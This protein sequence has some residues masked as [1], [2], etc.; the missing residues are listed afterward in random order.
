M[1]EKSTYET[2]R[3]TENELM[4]LISEEISRDM[5]RYPNRFNTEN[6]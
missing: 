2:E 1:D 3:S 4:H 5:R 6:E